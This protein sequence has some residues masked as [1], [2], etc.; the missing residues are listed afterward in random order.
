M[1]EIKPYNPQDA[2][3]LCG[4]ESK[5]DAANL[6]QTAGPAYSLFLDKKLVAC[7]GMRIYGVAELFL[8][9]SDEYR[10]KHIKTILKASREQ[11]DIMVRE[12]HIW[13]LLAETKIS[14]NFLKHL[15]FVESD[16]KLFMR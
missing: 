1:I 5:R 3:D 12:N 4:D 11:I 2:I 6:N 14:D 9:T 10:K 15:G 16:K 8:I 13:R 7:G